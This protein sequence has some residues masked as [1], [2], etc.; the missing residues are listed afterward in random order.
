MT[1]KLNINK[2]VEKMKEGVKEAKKAEKAPK[3]A[4]NPVIKTGP[5]ERDMRQEAREMGAHGASE[6]F[7]EH[8]SE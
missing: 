1:T 5:R 6:F 7:P 3:T 8:Q 4:F 2:I